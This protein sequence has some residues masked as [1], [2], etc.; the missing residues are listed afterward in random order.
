MVLGCV[1]YICPVQLTLRDASVVACV[2]PWRVVNEMRSRDHLI[3]R[4]DDTRAW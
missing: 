2:S 3:G 4:F 1:A